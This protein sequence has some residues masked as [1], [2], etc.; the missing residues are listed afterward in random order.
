M[1]YKEKIFNE[2]MLD[3]KKKKIQLHIN[4]NNSTNRNEFESNHESAA[5][6]VNLLPI[7]NS[8]IPSHNAFIGNVL[9]KI[10]TKKTDNYLFNNLIVKYNSEISI[11]LK[12]F[13]KCLLNNYKCDD[14]QIRQTCIKPEIKELIL[15]C[16]LAKTVETFI[17]LIIKDEIKFEIDIISGFYDKPYLEELYKYLN[18][19]FFGLNLLYFYFLMLKT[20]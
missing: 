8:D 17:S 15:R 7:Y 2:I 13:L 18:F 19:L 16:K 9:D 1:N 10:K 4:I 14:S 11:I 20:I 12:F 6:I 5:N 3:L